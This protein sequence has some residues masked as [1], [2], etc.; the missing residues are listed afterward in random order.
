[1]T[2]IEQIAAIRDTAKAVRG[3]MRSDYSGRSMFGR[4]CYGI[5]CADDTECVV[6]AARRGLPKPSI[7]SLAH[8]YVVYWP[9]IAPELATASR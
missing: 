5:D 2:L 4:L 7:D 3:E 8:G 1:M 9:T 6:Q